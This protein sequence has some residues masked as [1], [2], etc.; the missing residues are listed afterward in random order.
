MKFKLPSLHLLTNK[1]KKISGDNPSKYIHVLSGYAFV[2]HKIIAAVNLREYIKCEC[3]IDSDDDIAELDNI[4]EWLEGK[5]FTSEFWSNLTKENIVKFAEEGLVL[6]QPTFTSQLHYQNVELDLRAPMSAVSSNLDLEEVSLYRISFMGS[7]VD[8]LHKAFKNELKK[9]ILNL[10]F[11][12]AS[13]TVNFCLSQRNFIFGAI[14]STNNAAS[15]L[16]SFIENKELKSVLQNH[17]AS[18][19]P[20]APL[21]TAGYDI[22]SDDDELDEVPVGDLFQD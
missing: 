19:P 11:S 17:L 7:D 2:N 16:M 15:E 21:P 20:L 9:D 14:G 18:L 5:S 4:L 10:E 1:N 12:G 3:D 13:K 6:E 8:L 22:D